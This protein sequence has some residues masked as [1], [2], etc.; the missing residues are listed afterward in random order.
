MKAAPYPCGRTPARVCMT[1]AER[2]L[3]IAPKCAYAVSL[4]VFLAKVLANGLNLANLNRSSWRSSNFSTSPDGPAPD[5]KAL[6]LLENQ[7]MNLA[8][9]VTQEDVENV[10]ASNELLVNTPN[11]TSIASIAKQVMPSLDFDLI[12]QAA[13]YG[14]DLDQQTDYAND[15]IARQLREQGILAPLE[16]VTA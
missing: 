8:Y 14:D 16:E 3:E 13:L 10:L 15:E 5:G 12:E 1:N 7:S 9:Q 4:S 11:V 6:H 2:Q